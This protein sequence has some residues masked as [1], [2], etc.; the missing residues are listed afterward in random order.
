MESKR[1][2]AAG[3]SVVVASHNTGKTQEITDL[4]APFSV[5]P[6]S[7]SEHPFPE[8]EETGI[9]FRENAEIKAI[10]AAKATGLVALADDSGLEVDALD[11]EPGVFSARWAGP[12]KD[13]QMAMLRVER[14]LS[15]IKALDPQHRQANFVCDLCLA[16]PDGELSHF[17]GRVHGTLIW[18][19]RGGKGF[20]YDPIF[21]PH[22]YSQ[23]FGEM[24]VSTKHSISHRAQAFRLFIDACF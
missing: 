15:E 19:P 3:D 22:G 9:T 7:S 1:K 2:F 4:L 14:S 11:G 23:T 5:K 20:G 18:P 16:W 13:F 12:D 8:P 21:L 10:S 17:E 6:V 24:D